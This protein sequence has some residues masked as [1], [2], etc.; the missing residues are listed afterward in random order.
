[1]RLLFGQTADT[2]LKSVDFHF[3]SSELYGPSVCCLI[4][5]VHLSDV[6]VETM[7]AHVLFKTSIHPLLVL[8]RIYVPRLE[9]PGNAYQ[10][11]QSQLKI[12]NSA[13]VNV[14]W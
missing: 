6:Q 14:P 3:A 9:Y 2:M 11:C 4:C 7:R 13:W 10:P 5:R 12:T 8:F 1:M